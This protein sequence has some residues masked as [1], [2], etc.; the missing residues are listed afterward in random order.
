MI[1][2][3]VISRFL[4]DNSTGKY[5]ITLKAPDTLPIL[6]F[7]T[8]P[9]TRQLVNEALSKK[10]HDENTPRFLEV[11]KLRHECATLL[12]YQSHGHY[13]CETKMVETPE[14]AE[15][16]LLELL[17]VYRPKCLEEL[18]LL[19]DM[20]RKDFVDSAANAKNEDDSKLDPWDVSYYTQLYK[21]KYAG[22]D[23]AALREFF[24]L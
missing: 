1:G 12:G 10:C 17:E 22:V 15:E 3:E 2:V 19:L 11:L 13:M 5:I 23:E 18:D 14:K 8:N 20:K 24:P 4:R 7:A 16:F 6:K 21:S 9:R